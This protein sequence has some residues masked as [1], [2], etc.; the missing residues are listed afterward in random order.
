MR[1]IENQVINVLRTV[2]DPEIP[3]NIYDLGLIYGLSIE[4]SGIV[5]I[6]MTLTAPGCPVAGMIVQEVD[7]KVRTIPGIAHVSID[8]V[9]VPPWTHDMMSDD[10]K[11]LLDF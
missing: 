3:L 4:P 10:A 5:A 6:T 2:R 1:E 9:W 11:L 8:L 7:S